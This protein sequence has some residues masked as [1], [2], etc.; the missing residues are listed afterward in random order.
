MPRSSVVDVEFFFFKIGCAFQRWGSELHSI[1]Y[2]RRSLGIQKLYVRGRTCCTPL[3]ARNTEGAASFS[4][5]S[6]SEPSCR[7]IGY[8]KLWL[9]QGTTGSGTV[10][11]AV[12]HSGAGVSVSSGPWEMR[13]QRFQ[14]ALSDIIGRFCGRSSSGACGAVA[15]GASAADSSAIGAVSAMT[16]R[17]SQA[18]VR[19]LWPAG[20]SGHEALPL[21][22]PSST[23]GAGFWRARMDFAPRATFPLVCRCF[24]TRRFSQLQG[25][26]SKVLEK[27]KGCVDVPL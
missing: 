16:A 12:L 4:S 22:A 1:D 24:A 27:S 7:A 3:P 5:F 8:G 9:T 10:G 6:S 14:R 2:L 23:P 11:S 25:Q 26:A 17:A 20:S 15:A 18:I 21:Q 13:H 19:S